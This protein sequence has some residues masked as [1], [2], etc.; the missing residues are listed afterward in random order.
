M[1]AVT[2]GLKSTNIVTL[3]KAVEDAVKLVSYAPNRHALRNVWLPSLMSTHHYDEALDLAHRGILLAASDLEYIEALQSTK[4]RALL[5]M[6]RY[7]EAASEA[8]SLFNVCSMRG[9]G[10][11]ISLL[12][13]CLAAAH[14]DDP[15]IADRLKEEQAKGSQA[16]ADG[17]VRS[18]LLDTI[19][20]DPAPYEV[21]STWHPRVPVQFK[22]KGD[23]LLMAGK[24]QEARDCFEQAMAVD[25]RGND[26]VMTMEGLARCMK[27]EDGTTG[28]AEAWLAKQSS[29]K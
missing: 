22:S 11:T 6:G 15:G 29:G 10:Q 27:A 7:P 17:A 14:P 3:A 26:R 21:A 25:T 5:I 8:K 19:K 13:E 12:A 16:P 18:P 2:A 9:T 20:V 4:V 1:E 28:R 23:L 24:V